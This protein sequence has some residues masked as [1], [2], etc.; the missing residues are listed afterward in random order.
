MPQGVRFA[1]RPPLV[2]GGVGIVMKVKL[3]SSTVLV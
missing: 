3:M 2:V 1:M